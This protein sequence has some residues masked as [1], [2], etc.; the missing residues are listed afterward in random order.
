MGYDDL[1]VIEANTF[2]QSVADGEQ[3]A[4]GLAEMLDAATVLDAVVRS[5]RTGTGRPSVGADSYPGGRA[6]VRSGPTSSRG[7]PRRRADPAAPG[8]APPPDSGPRKRALSS[9]Y[10]FG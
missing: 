10:A 7:C 8:P 4:P 2:L 1:K 6:G 5:S 3:R 9:Q